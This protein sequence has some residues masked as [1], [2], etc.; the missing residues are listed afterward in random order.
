[1]A[2]LKQC[3]EQRDASSVEA[4]VQELQA[5][6]QHY[7]RL[8]RDGPSELEHGDFLFE[9]AWANDMIV[10]TSAVLLGEPDAEHYERAIAESPL[11]RMWVASLLVM[12]I[13]LKVRSG[14]TVAEDL[15]F[16]PQRVPIELAP[17]THD[18]AQA[19]LRSWRRFG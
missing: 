18:H 9:Q 16:F 14:F 19:A 3:L 17:V 1:M 15:N 4:H 12:A 10:D 8:L 2:V 6:Y 5:L 13:V 7:A 11:Y